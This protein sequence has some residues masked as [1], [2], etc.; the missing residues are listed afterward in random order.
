VTDTR[1]E[2]GGLFSLYLWVT[3]LAVAAVFVATLYA[4]ARYRR[5]TDEPSRK[6]E[7]K[8]AES[9]YAVALAI[10]A[11]ALVAATFR[12]EDRVDPVRPK[13]GLRVAITGFQWQWRFDYPNG[14][15][16][17][18]TRDRLPVLVVPVDTLIRFTATSQDVIHSF[19]I[20]DVRFKRDTF[21]NRTTTFDLVFDHEGDL[22]GHCA[23]FCGLRHTN[24]DFI[25]R[26]VGADAF[27]RWQTE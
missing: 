4:V 24:M 14:R 16:V 12:T 19:W 20:P 8:L 22:L 15:S 11:V 17:L 7:A 26:V 5:R 21:P 3:G 1:T 23:E 9:L 27:R 6:D 18:G 2:F 10:V 13:P 25:V